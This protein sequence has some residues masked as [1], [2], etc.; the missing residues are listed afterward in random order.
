MR[1]IHFVLDEANR[2]GKMSLSS[3][4]RLQKRLQHNVTGSSLV[5]DEYV[6]Y[7]IRRFTGADLIQCNS[8]SV[9]N[10]ALFA[11]ITFDTGLAQGS[12]TFPQLFNIFINTLLR[13]LTAAA[14][15][16]GSSYGLQ[17]GKDQEES[18]HDA[19][20]GYQFHDTG[21]IV[22]ISILLRPQKECKQDTW[23]T[24]QNSKHQ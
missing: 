6:S 23:R 13:M 1:K 21:F 3:R 7:T 11:T 17:I 18:S 9:P 12:I 14:Q 4:Y 16:Q 24:S 5:R 10:D 8:P 22:S 15:N 20:H 2:Q 19:D